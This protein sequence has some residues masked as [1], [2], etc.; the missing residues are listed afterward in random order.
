MVQ[1]IKLKSSDN[2][3]F[4]VDIAIVKCSSLIKTMLEDLG[5]EEGED[6]LVP[7]ANVN[8]P[9]L[10]RVIKWATFHKVVK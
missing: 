7:L 2:D 4:E 5:I 8:T 1:K 10:T 3:V 6:E 9:V